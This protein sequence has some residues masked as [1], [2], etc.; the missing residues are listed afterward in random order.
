MATRSQVISGRVRLVF[1][2]VVVFALGLVYRLYSI[3]IV[4]G[5]EYSI[6]AD[7]QYITSDSS[8]LNRGTIY[9]TS[10]DGDKVTAA[11]QQTGNIIVIN[12]KQIIDKEAVFE[13]I[14]S[15]IPIDKE[16]FMRKADKK[17]D[18]YEEIVKKVDT[19]IGEK[20]RA[21]ALP[22]LQVFKQKW[23]S[24]PGSQIAG[25][26][27]GF[28]A[29]DHEELAG[30]YGLEHQYENTLRRTDSDS[31][32]NFFVEVFSNIK[33]QF[34]EGENGE[35]DIIT[36]IEPNVQTYLEQVLK[37]I[38][39][40][41]SSDFTAGIVM[42]PNTGEIIGMGQ[43]PVFDLN[44]FGSV[45]DS[46]LF[47]NHL[48]QDVHEMGSIIKPLT[49]AA[50]I[51]S[52]AVTSKTTY[53][54][55]GFLVLN[56]K[57]ISNYDGKARGVVNMQEVL[58]QSLNTG[59]AFVTQKMG[60]DKFTEYFKNFGLDRKTGIDLPF[61]AAPLVD[62]LN[63]SR[64]IEHATASYGQGIAMTAISTT[65][66]LS[67]LANGGK[68]INPHVVSKIDYKN[69]LHRTIDPG[70]PVQVLKKE[71]S[72]EVTRMLIK[73]VDEALLHGTAKMEHYS[74]AAKTGTAQIANPAGGGYYTDRYLHSFF[75]YFPAYN[76]KFIIFLYTYY[77]KHVQYASETLT[78]SFFD[79]T[80]YL[81]NYYDI[82]PDR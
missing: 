80:K 71:T 70:K 2:L 68:L 53:N 82:P 58:S 72:E 4:D 10:K 61:E 37:D 19:E 39:D 75:G 9:F 32:A 45:K 55:K 18:P 30:R 29:Y 64:D 73:V 43:F 34:E 8:L 67:I 17:D 42:D 74:V 60:N 20:L 25:A 15:T 49:M 35:G 27:L 31:F 69:G 44:N 24:Y 38:N 28:V 56:S 7:R 12:P 77:P 40:K 41:W 36:T 26:T 62:N 6:K 33:H 59:V 5:E 79:M 14:N 78:A 3:Q 22:G 57:R 51:D 63:S 21:K 48:V 65:R 23:R 66:A 46:S 11:Y 1:V 50:G 16:E 54:D 52:G 47:T 81:I 13:A 76:P